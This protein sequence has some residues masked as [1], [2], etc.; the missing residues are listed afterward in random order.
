MSFSI[1]DL[2]EVGSEFEYGGKKYELRRPSLLEQAKFSQWLKDEV[3][4]EA[5]RGDVPDDVRA[6]LFRAAMRDIGERYYDPDA[7]AYIAAL[8]RPSGFAK[9]LH[10]ILQ[11]D[12]PD[13]P[14]DIVHGMLEQGLKEKFAQLVA[15]EH[16]DPN[17]VRAV[18]AML[19]LRPDWVNTSV[20]SSSASSTN[21]APPQSTAPAG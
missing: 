17:L 14:E 2:L 15:A 9:L 4:A 10:I 20:N 13:I 12:H 11:T 1:A 3:K 18:A 6:Q 19:G 21:T 7:E 8:Q 5:G 16:D